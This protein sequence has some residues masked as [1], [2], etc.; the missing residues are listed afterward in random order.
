MDNQNRLLTIL[1]VVL[2]VGVALLVVD[3]RKDQEPAPDGDG[4]PQHTLFGY[5]ADEVESF[6]IVRGG[7]ALQFQKQ[8]GRWVLQGSESVALDPRKV[9]EVLNRFATLKVEERDLKGPREEYGLDDAQRVELRVHTSAGKDHIAW[10]GLDS[11]V[12]Y[13]TYVQE[14]TNGPVQL[15]TSK[16][17]ELVHRGVADFRATD[18][19]SFSTAGTRRIVFQQGETTVAL[20]KDDHGWWLGDTGPRADDDA[21]RTWLYSVE[22]LKAESFLDGV[23]PASVGL[24]TPAASVRIEDDQG[25][26]TLDLGPPGPGRVAR[27]EHGLVR[28]GPDAVDPI[29]LDGWVSPRLLPVRRIQIDLLEVQLGED[30]GS[31][32]RSE[33]VWKDGAG[34]PAIAVDGL[35]DKIDAATA[36]RSVEVARPGTTWGTIKAAEGTQRSEEIRLGPPEGGWH[37]AWDVN[38]GPPFR[39]PADAV[40][41]IAAAVP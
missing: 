17:S 12:G 36:D 34:T 41:A 7:D 2:L 10:I 30:K 13:R 33:G 6:S 25:T 24:A 29:K 23:D 28:L 18:V 8:D 19:W 22:T 26:H 15:A 35:L 21:V 4:P 11:S 31:W 37:A 20:R 39:I 5:K 1:A 16:V 27:G 3:P 9:E 40:A 38:G 32:T 14:T